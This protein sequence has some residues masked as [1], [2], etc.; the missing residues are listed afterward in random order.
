MI[1]WVYV[2]ITLLAA[3]GGLMI[4]SLSISGAIAAFFVG[5]FISFGFEWK[6]LVLL[7][8]FFVSSSLWSKFQ[9]QKKES[10]HEKVEKGECRDYMQ[11]LA[12]GSVPA[13]ISLIY[14]FSPSTIWLEMFI[15][16]LAAA[17]A[18]T[19]ASEIG[20]IS[21]QPPR[22]ITT[23][24]MVEPGTSGGVTILGTISALAGAFFIAM[25]SYFLWRDIHFLY[26]T[27]FGFLGSM[28]DTWLGAVWQKNYRCAVC[29]LE[30][31]K[32][33]HCGHVTVGLKGFRFMNNDMVNWLSIGSTTILYAFVTKLL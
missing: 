9:N 33:Q 27:L 1:E 8:V 31:E 11:V 17:N 5:V 14:I 23:W 25:V 6:G 20:S 28:I 13:L 32:K 3:V 12:N 30:T 18:D 4:H 2:G 29:G 15:V 16:S 7:G 24:K 21:K 10:L 26:I 19:W 22:L